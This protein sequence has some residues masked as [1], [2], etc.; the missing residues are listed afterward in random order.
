MHY[1]LS[2]SVVLLASAA[3]L[4][5]SNALALEDYCTP[6]LNDYLEKL[7]KTV[8]SKYLPDSQKETAKKVLERVKAS[9]NETEDCIL[10]DKLM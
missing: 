4:G 8:D 10:V 7:E 2:F 9:R 3:I 1:K 5:S 6:K